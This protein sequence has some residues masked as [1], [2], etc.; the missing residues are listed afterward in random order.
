MRGQG[1]RDI[2]LVAVT[3][4]LAACGRAPSTAVAAT[5]P[6]A[7]PQPVVEQPAGWPA[8]LPTY[9]PPY[10]GGRVETAFEGSSAGAPPSGMVAFS[11]ADAPERVVSFYRDEAKRAGLGDVATMAASGA[12]MF[13]AND[14]ATHRALTIQAS[15][16]GPR[17]T[18]SLTW[19]N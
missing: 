13:T 2:G 4:L 1:W 17:T 6:V 14:R 12:Q 9:A 18:V 15:P 10:P 8:A 11:T 7:T 5:Q 19:S 16:D 3:G